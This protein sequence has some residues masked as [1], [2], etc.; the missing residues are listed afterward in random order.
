MAANYFAKKLR[1]QAHLLCVS[2]QVK[3]CLEIWK[4]VNWA[5]RASARAEKL[6]EFRLARTLAPPGDQTGPLPEIRLIWPDASL[7]SRHFR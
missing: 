4:P 5:G 7:E 1:V 3:P 6:N 2:L